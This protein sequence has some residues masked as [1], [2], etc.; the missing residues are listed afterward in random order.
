MLYGTHI[1][2]LYQD[3]L[4]CPVQTRS[5]LHLSAQSDVFWALI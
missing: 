5:D 1:E 4:V 3:I 2:N